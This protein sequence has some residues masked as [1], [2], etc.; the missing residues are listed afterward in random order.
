VPGGEK[1]K[2]DL[3]FVEAMQR[4]LFEHRIDR[5]SYVI[6]IGGGAM[7]DAVGL[8]AA[9]SHRGVRHIRVPT[10][11]LAQ[12][13]SGVGVKNGVNLHGVKNY[14][15]TFTLPFAVL[16]RPRP[17]RRAERDKRAGMAEAVKL[18]IIRDVEFFRWLE[19]NSDEWCCPPRY[20]VWPLARPL[21]GATSSWPSLECVE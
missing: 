20:R 10:T 12:N 8:V 17:D 1:I 6:G 9:T 7:L 18:A 14:V 3:H 5:H 11:V 21:F 16:K 4:R 13:D 2:V 19:R 15:G